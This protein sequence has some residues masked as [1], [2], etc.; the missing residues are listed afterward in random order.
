MNIVNQVIKRIDSY[1]RSRGFS[2]FEKNYYY[3]SNDIAYCISF[4]MPGGLLYVTAYIMPLYLPCECR[5]YS[6]GRRLNN[7]YKRLFTLKKNDNNE[8]ICQWCEE[9]CQC[10]EKE[11]LPVYKQIETPD[12]L[13]EHIENTNGLAYRFFTCPPVFIERL[14]MFTYLYLRDIN[15]IR[16]ALEDY[17]DLIRSSS[18]FTS[19]VCENL[20]EEANLLE[21]YIQEKPEAS[22]AYL[23]EKSDFTKKLFEASQK[24]RG[25]GDGSVV[26]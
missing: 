12:I 25:Q 26:S 6:Y 17:R 1:M 14:K 18:F 24:K 7:H 4:E 23:S 21:Y 16:I 20:L 19:A 13:L 8:T 2:L 15:K 9:L 22:A 11:I 10:I 3:I 5:Y